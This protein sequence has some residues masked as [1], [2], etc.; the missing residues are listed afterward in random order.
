MEFIHGHAWVNSEIYLIA[1]Y[2]YGV[3]FKINPDLEY[4]YYTDCNLLKYQ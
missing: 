4:A 2:E 1:L 3:I